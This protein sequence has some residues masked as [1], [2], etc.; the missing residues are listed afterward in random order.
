MI[1]CIYRFQIEKKSLSFPVTSSSLLCTNRLWCVLCIL[2]SCITLLGCIL[3][4]EEC[5]IFKLHKSTWFLQ[6]Q[7]CNGWEKEFL[8]KWNFTSLGIFCVWYK[9]TDL[10]ECISSGSRYCSRSP[11]KLIPTETK[12]HHLKICLGFSVG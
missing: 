11:E 6:S 8:L 1:F 3:A 4:S 10:M 9:T 12:R 5:Q 2:I 7:I